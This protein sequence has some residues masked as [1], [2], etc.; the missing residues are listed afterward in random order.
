MESDMLA[1]AKIL[2]FDNL[3]YDGQWI[4]FNKARMFGWTGEQPSV[5]GTH[6]ADVQLNAALDYLLEQ[7]VTFRRAN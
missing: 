2:G 5:L 3:G 4:V 1:K 6:T 7:K